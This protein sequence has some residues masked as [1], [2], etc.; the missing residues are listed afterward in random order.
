MYFSSTLRLILLFLAISQYQICSAATSV[1]CYS[2]RIVFFFGGDY[3]TGQFVNGDYWVHNNGGNVEIT[4]I[5]PASEITSGRTINGT[6]VNPPV[7]TVQ[8][9]DS[10]PRDMSYDNLLNVDP[11]NTGISL[12]VAPGTSIIKSISMA[13]DEG[14]PIIGDAVVLTVLDQAPPPNA[15]RPPYTGVDKSIPA[16]LDDVDFSVLGRYPKLGNEPDIEVVADRY[17]RVWLEHCT[18]WVQR[19]IHPEN[20]M[21]AYGRDIARSLADGLI[22]LQ[23]NYANEEKQT[24]LIRLVQ[25]GIDLYGVARNGGVWYNNGGHNLGRKMSL[26]LAAMTLHNSEMLAYG[27]KEQHFIFQDDQQHFYVSQAEVDRTHCVGCNVCSDCWDPDSRAEAIAYETAD[28]G[29]A[30]WGIR[31]ADRPKADNANWGATYRSVNGYAQTMQIFA[32]RLMGVSEQWNWPPVFDYA[33]RFYGIE[34]QG[35]AE[36]FQKLW[37]GYRVLMDHNQEA[38]L[39]G[40][41]SVDL[42][43][44]ILGLRVLVDQRPAGIRADFSSSGADIHKDGVISFAEVLKALEGSLSD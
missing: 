4:S 21:P 24:L 36:Y 12:V 14:R 17:Q 22:L 29:T 19:D 27:D 15:F 8:G 20:N 37:S 3:E 42:Q 30:E 1:S 18:E 31:H 11:G 2:D 10:H 44:A 26:L 6:M 38:D 41:D 13:A 23:L 28:I 7:S 35:F 32:A 9:Y 16:T 25:Y 5:S 43:D 34:Q 40:D 33:D 39:N